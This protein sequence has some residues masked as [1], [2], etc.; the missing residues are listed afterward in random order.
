MSLKYEPASE[1]QAL[2]L[3]LGVC[4]LERGRDHGRRRHR[5]QVSPNSALEDLRFTLT[6]PPKGLTTT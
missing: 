6:N 2:A 1:P 3:V 5:R 4:D